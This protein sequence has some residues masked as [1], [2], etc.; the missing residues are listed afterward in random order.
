MVES[1]Q[2]HGSNIAS[3]Q[4]DM[5]ERRWFIVGCHLAPYNASYIEQVV[6]A[7]GQRPHR[8]NLMMVVDFNA[9]I[10]DLEGNT[11]DEAFVVVLSDAGLKEMYSNFLPRRIPWAWDGLTWSMIRKGK[12]VWYQMD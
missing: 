5:G 7:T 1:H 9:D 2:K 6:G 10:A 12:E 3:F 4:M 8:D 11:Q